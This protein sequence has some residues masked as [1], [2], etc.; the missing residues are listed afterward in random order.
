MYVIYVEREYD[1][2]YL[3]ARMSVSVSFSKF[4]TLSLIYVER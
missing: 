4:G 3:H 2:V 1:Q